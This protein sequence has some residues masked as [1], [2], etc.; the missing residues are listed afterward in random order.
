MS[1]KTMLLSMFF[2]FVIIAIVCGMPNYPYTKR[3][4]EEE[5]PMPEVQYEL[6][7][8][9]VGEFVMVASDCDHYI[10][11]FPNNKYILLHDL[12]GHVPFETYGYIVNKDNVWYFSPAPETHRPYFNELKKI[13]IS[14]SGFFFYHDDYPT[15]AWPVRSMRKKNIPV[16]E[17]LAS[18]IT[19]T[20]RKITRQYFVLGTEMIDFNEIYNLHDHY[21]HE[22]RIDNGILYIFLC[23]DDNTAA[24]FFYG[25]ID[26]RYESTDTVR[27]T[28]KFTNGIAYYYVNDGIANIEIKRDGGIIITMLYS[29]PSEYISRY[30]REIPGLQFP[31]T[32]VL[33]F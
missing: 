15:P 31:A 21:Y 1:K 7:E 29:P 9:L 20:D 33:E 6:P 27:G 30:I 23:Y 13:H 4:T 5:I 10:T 14:D 2:I 24:L 17:H 12:A 16:P 26:K 18:D 22:L 19:V 3:I 25:F 32:L 8:V 28:I 11:I